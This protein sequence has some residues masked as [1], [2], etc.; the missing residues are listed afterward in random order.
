MAARHIG[1]IRDIFHLFF[2]VR[3]RICGTKP[4]M[5]PLHLMSHSLSV[6][7]LGSCSTKQSDNMLPLRS[8]AASTYLQRCVVSK[9]KVTFFCIKERKKTLAEEQKRNE[10]NNVERENHFCSDWDLKKS[11]ALPVEWGQNAAYHMGD[12]IRCFFCAGPNLPRRGLGQ[13][14]R[15]DAGFG[16]RWPL[17]AF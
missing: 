2:F 4:Q 8:K 11:T 15:C 17:S 10:K 13:T 1:V 14:S 7:L 3:L 12:K 16:A 6:R 9:R 5:E